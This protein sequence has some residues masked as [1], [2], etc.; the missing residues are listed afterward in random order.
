MSVYSEAKRRDPSMPVTIAPVAAIDISKTRPGGPEGPIVVASNRLPFSVV[1]NSRGLE[2]QPSPGGLVS[3]TQDIIQAML[4]ATVPTIVFV[5]P[6]GATATSA[7]TF[8][9]LAANANRFSDRRQRNRNPTAFS[10]RSQRL[11]NMG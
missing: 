2:R 11:D 9:T 3:A 7:G 5:T 6:R 1:R 10:K 8:I 4:N